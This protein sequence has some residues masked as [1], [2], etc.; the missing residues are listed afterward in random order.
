MVIEEQKDTLESTESSLEKQDEN[1]E[2]VA[3]VESELEES[4][5]NTNDISR[6]EENSENQQ[7]ISVLEQEEISVY[8]TEDE[9]K[10]LKKVSEWPRCLDTASNKLE[11]HRIPVYLYELSSEFHSYWNMGC[12][13]Y[14]S[15]SPRDLSTSRMPSSA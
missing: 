10:I 13:L 8:Y 14:T 7:G 12:L 11:P 3:A 15:P 2:D 6:I 9:I 5:E 4:S 1:I